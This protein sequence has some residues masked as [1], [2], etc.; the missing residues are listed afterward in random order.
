[1][2]E[3]DVCLGDVCAVP[4]LRGLHLVRTIAPWAQAHGI[5]EVTA[6]WD[7]VLALAARP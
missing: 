6:K 1:M 4:L 5:L 3:G 2:A 7:L